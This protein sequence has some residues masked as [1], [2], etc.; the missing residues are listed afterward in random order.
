MHHLPVPPNSGTHPRGLRSRMNE[1]RTADETGAQVIEYAMLGAVA[2]AACG[3]LVAIIKGGVLDT[4]METITSGL[5]ELVQ[6][7]F[8]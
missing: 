6:T 1:L 5:V 3:A 4:V 7:W 8:A 2:A